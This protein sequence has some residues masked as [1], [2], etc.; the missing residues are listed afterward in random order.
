MGSI[1]LNIDDAILQKARQRAQSEGQ[2][3]DQI[4]S[5]MLYEWTIVWSPPGIPKGAQRYTIRSGDTL[6]QI[7]LRFYGN[8]KRY[9]DI[10]QA[11]GI[12]NPGMI[13]VGQILII[14]DL[15]VQQ[16][17]EP[18]PVQPTPVQ[19]TPVTL[20]PALDIEFIESP[21]Y[22]RRPAGSRIWCIV[23]HATANSTLEGVIKWFL[24]PQSFVSAH[25][26]IGKDGRIVQMVQDELRGWHAGKSTW[27]GVADVN[28]YSIGIELVNLNNGQDPYP[29]AQYQTTVTLCKTLMQKYGIQAEDIVSHKAIS[30]SGKTDPMGLDMDQLRRDVVS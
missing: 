11:N 20:A 15:S 7:A 10:A 5:K 22:N 26:N 13:R 29:P 24:N 19:P 18:T 2:P 17:P 16:A 4:V 1:S 14:P 23:V 30:L 12:T 9:I 6:A 27:K 3:L 8:A 28:N 25:Y 21:H